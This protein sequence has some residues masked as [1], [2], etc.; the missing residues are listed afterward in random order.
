M[1]GLLDEC[2][3]EWMR[4]RIGVKDWLDESLSN[5]VSEWVGQLVSHPVS[6]TVSHFVINSHTLI[7]YSE[8]KLIFPDGSRIKGFIQQD[9]HHKGMGGLL[10]E[11]MS[12]WV[13]EPYWCEILTEWIM[14]NWVS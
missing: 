6:Q 12:E 1:G 5:W 9:F 10:D 3:S 4:S 14:S 2:V 13:S 8:K 11:W 7:S